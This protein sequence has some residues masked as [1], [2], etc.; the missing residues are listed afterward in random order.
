LTCRRRQEQLASNR[1]HLGEITFGQ[2]DR[3]F[4]QLQ[5]QLLSEFPVCANFACDPLVTRSLYLDDNVL[6]DSQF[7]RTLRIL[8]LRLRC[9]VSPGSVN[10]NPGQLRIDPLNFP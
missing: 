10:H 1:P 7:L 4:M 5:L 2:R 6:P 8:E 9:E 3:V